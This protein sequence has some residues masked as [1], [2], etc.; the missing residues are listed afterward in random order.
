MF[1]SASEGKAEIYKTTLGCMRRK[2]LILGLL[3][4]CIEVN[5]TIHNVDI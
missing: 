2:I 3:N 4:L 5:V 1:K